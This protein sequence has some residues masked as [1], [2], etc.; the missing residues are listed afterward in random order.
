MYIKQQI[1]PYKEISYT[2]PVRCLKE[3]GDL[4]PRL[5]NEVDV[6]DLHGMWDVLVL[7]LPHES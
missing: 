3:Y 1:N 6:W 4:L 2:E 7:R 5:A